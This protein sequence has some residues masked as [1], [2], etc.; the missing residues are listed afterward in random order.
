MPSIR[1]AHALEDIPVGQWDALHDG[2]NPF[3][4][5]A[6]LAGLEQHGCLRARY[7]W[8]PQHLT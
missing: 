3:V 7:G 6:F 2:R 4:T 5:H 8:T 1:I